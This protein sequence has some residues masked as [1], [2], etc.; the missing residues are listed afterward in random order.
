[1]DRRRSLLGV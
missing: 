1:M